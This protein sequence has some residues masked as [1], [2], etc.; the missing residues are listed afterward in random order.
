[1]HLL[2]VEDDAD[3]QHIIR[4]VMDEIDS[5][6]AVDFAGNGEEA[7]K[8][9]KAMKKLPDIIFT[10]INMPRMNGLETLRALKQQVRYSQIP[11]FILSTSDDRVSLSAARHL[12]AEGYIV[13]PLHFDKLRQCILQA[14]RIEYNM[15]RSLRPG[16]FLHLP[17]GVS[18]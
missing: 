17:L 5:T 8:M 12:G 6:I 13:K 10:D 9:L 7:L 18:Y 4:T 11:V 14:L 15:P 1:M 3:D 16:Q 2:F